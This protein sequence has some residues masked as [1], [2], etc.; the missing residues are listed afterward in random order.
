MEQVIERAARHV[1]LSVEEMIHG[2][3]EWRPLLGRY[4]AAYLLVTECKMTLKQT[5]A[6]L[7]G[8]HHSTVINCLRR[9]VEDRK[10]RNHYLLMK[11]RLPIMNER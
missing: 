1:N 7:G 3:R 9:V 6:A 2:G 10:V 4:L 5:G 11:G 8:L